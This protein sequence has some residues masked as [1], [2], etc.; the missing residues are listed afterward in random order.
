MLYI[1]ADI[2][3]QENPIE[4]Q[5]S[6]MVSSP[7]LSENRTRYPCS[8]KLLGFEQ[9]FRRQSI[10]VNRMPREDS[11]GNTGSGK[12]DLRDM[13]GVVTDSEKHGVFSQSLAQTHHL[14]KLAQSQSH[15]WLQENTSRVRLILGQPLFVSLSRNPLQL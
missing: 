6:F 8:V 4:T 11:H 10:G 14:A 1:M 3:P 13:W 12:G 9:I 7:L 15:S 5:Y 2:L